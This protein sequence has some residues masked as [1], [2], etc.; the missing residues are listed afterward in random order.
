MTP[1]EP[2]LD[3]WPLLR[4][5]AFASKQAAFRMIVHGRS[6]GVVPSCLSSFVEDLQSRRS[7]PVQLQALT[8]EERPLLPNR[9]WFCFPCCSGQA[10]ML[11]SMY[12]RFVKACDSTEQRS[13]C[14]L[15]L[16]LGRFGGGWWPLHYT[17]SWGLTLCWCTIRC[18]R[19]LRIVS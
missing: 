17:D 11:E 10:P 9:P 18:A 6:G 1:G 7:A 5:S 19:E 8:A 15:F 14:F 4:N 12:Q 16:V 2:H 3:P 13:R